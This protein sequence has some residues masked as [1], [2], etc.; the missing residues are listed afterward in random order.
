MSLSVLSNEAGNTRPYLSDYCVKPKKLIWGSSVV[1]VVVVVFAILNK[2]ESARSKLTQNLELIG[3][4]Y[5]CVTC[6]NIQKKE[7]KSKANKLGKQ[8]RIEYCSTAQ[9]RQQVL[10]I[11]VY[12]QIQRYTHAPFGIVCLVVC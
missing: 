1:V 4:T 3:Q 7:D 9:H 11:L 2:I 8:N 5:R 10:E 6:D 12:S